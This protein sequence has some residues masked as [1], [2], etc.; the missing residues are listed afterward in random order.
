MRKVVFDEGP[1]TYT[2]TDTNQQY[3]SVTTLI[4]KYEIPF[5]THYWSTY[6][7]CKDVL[8]N[9]HMWEKYKRKAGGWKDVVAHFERNKAGRFTEDVI[10]RIN[11]YVNKWEFAKNSACAA[12]TKI[13]K[14]KEEEILAQDGIETS[15][16]VRLTAIESC[17]IDHLKRVKNGVFPELLVYDTE[18]DIAGQVDLVYKKGKKIII[19]DYKTNNE[20]SR[21]A[22]AD[23]KMKVPLD[24][25]LDSTFNHYMLQM[26]L[27]AWILERQGYEIVELELI[28]L[29]RET[30]DVIDE[31]EVPY[32]PDL[33]E[34]MVKHYRSEHRK[35][36]KGSMLNVW[37]KI[38]E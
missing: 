19:K 23:N 6:K 11:W 35:V 22:F 31:I 25:L 5:D 34:K 16:G 38:K 20:I 1:H 24:N 8:E 29:D 12:G 14:Q 21:E 36:V 30:G 26:S 17:D 3:I 37:V 18:Y 33:V 32:V 4:G 10:N 7:G 15:S 28:H 2:D 9:V 13:H 27:Y